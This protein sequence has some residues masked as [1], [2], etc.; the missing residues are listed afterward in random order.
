M[1]SKLAGFALQIRWLWVQRTNDERAW[2]QL[3]LNTT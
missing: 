1:D 2:S 3:P